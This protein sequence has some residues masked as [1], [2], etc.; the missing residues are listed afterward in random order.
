MTKRELE[1]LLKEAG[2]EIISGTRHDMAV[3]DG[4]STK[5]PIPRHKG[6]IPK[7][8]ANNILKAAGLR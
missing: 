8:T 2:W 5:I 6:D 3:K 1:K 7:G 4:S